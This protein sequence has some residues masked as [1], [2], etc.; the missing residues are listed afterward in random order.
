M[1]PRLRLWAA[2]TLGLALLVPLVVLAGRKERP[3]AGDKTSRLH[4]GWRITPVGSQQKLGDMLLGCALSP[5][6]SL[7]A[8][9]NTGYND[10]HLYLVE[11]QTG[12]VRQTLP[13]AREFVL[14]DNTYCNGDVSGNGHPWSTAAYGTDIGE[15]AWMQTYSG[16][17]AWPLT[18][19]DL[20]PPVGRSWDACERKGLPGSPTTSLGRRT[21]PR[22][23][24]LSPGKRGSGSGAIR[25]MP[26]CSSPI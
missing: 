17:A 6:G 24:C 20:Y 25:R 5:D 2:L 14:L 26:T 18:E 13:M 15:R 9:T 16:R 7:L 22:R 1:R 11:T 19:R 4:N 8:L 21:T 23:I 10:H 3:A 12:T